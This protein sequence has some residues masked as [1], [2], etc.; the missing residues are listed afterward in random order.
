MRKECIVQK[1]YEITSENSKNQVRENTGEW[2][3][4]YGLYGKRICH[5]CVENF[6]DW[7]FQDPMT[8]LNPT[9]TVGKQIGGGGEDP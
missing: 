5:G 4:Y 2:S 7:S 6:F 8:S 1:Y 9:I 3:G